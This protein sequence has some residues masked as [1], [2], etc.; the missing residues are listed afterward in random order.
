MN[1]G[2]IGLGRMGSGLAHR[3]LEG[4]HEVL[5][6]NR[7]QDKVTPIVEAGGKQVKTLEDFKQL[8]TPRVV[9]VM[10]PAGEVTEEIIFGDGGLT[11]ILEK[12]DILIDGGNSHYTDTIT[13]ALRLR[14]H[15]IEMLDIGT[16]G[17]LGGRENGYCLMIGGPKE[18]YDHITPVLGTIAQ[19]EGYGYFGTSGAGHYTK[20]VHNAIE[21]GMMQSIAEG[22]ALLMEGEFR[23]VSLA[24][25]ANVWQ[26][27]S[28]VQSY[29]VGL[30]EQIFTENPTLKGVPGVVNENGEARWTVEAAK[31]LGVELPSI[32]LSLQVRRESQEG[33]VTN[34]TKILASL[35]NKFGGHSFEKES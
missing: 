28:I 12:G 17:G 7:S 25:A 18:A 23:D 27:G 29:L 30:I 1:I 24:K 22:C 20:M 15:G 2:I 9:W 11:S 21:Y 32:E 3:L 6:Y 35:R 13:R 19:P 16:S 10:L 33:K 31:R 5:A 26:H 34:T 4:G 14:K 8:P